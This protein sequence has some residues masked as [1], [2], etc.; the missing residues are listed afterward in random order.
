MM[1]GTA[2][3]RPPSPALAYD[4]P[5]EGYRVFLGLFARRIS[6][7]TVFSYPVKPYITSDMRSDMVGFDMGNSNVPLDTAYLT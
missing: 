6:Y 5:G 2:R 7:V 1:P 3:Y 4:I